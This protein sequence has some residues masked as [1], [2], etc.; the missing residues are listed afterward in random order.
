MNVRDL[1]YDLPS[2][3]IAQHPAEPRDASR[4]LVLDRG[5]SRLTHTHFRQLPDH[6]RGGDCLVINQTRV[7]PARFFATRRT[8]ARVEGLYLASQ[9]DNCWLVLLRPARRLRAAEALTVAGGPWSL[10]LIERI[11]KGQWLLRPHPEVS[12]QTF[13]EQVG[14][15]PLPPYIKRPHQRYD[16]H[17]DR[18]RYQTVYAAQPGAVAAPTAG[19]HFTPAL[20]KQIQAANI[21]IAPLTLHVGLGT[22]EPITAQRLHDHRMHAEAYDL[23]AAAAGEINAARSSGG[24]IVCVGTT[25]ARVLETCAASDGSVRPAAGQT[26]LFIYPPY[27]FRAVDALLTNFHLPGSTLLALVFAFAGR[28]QILHAYQEAVHL[29]YRFYSYGDAML[30]L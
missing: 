10:E 23:P 13:L 21:R 7:L 12:V 14:V 26:D 9:S 22:F 15:T 6:L 25:C 19:L 30:I 18:Q 16:D 28:E 3:L 20:L 8:G 11:E 24:R 1:Q 17:S 29:R 5:A 27:R 2:E 4:L